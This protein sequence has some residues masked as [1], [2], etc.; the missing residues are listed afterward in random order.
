MVKTRKKKKTPY[1]PPHGYIRIPMPVLA[2][3]RLAAD[4]EGVTQA[5]LL[6]ALVRQ[7]VVERGIE[8]PIAELMAHAEAVEIVRQAW[9]TEL[10]NRWRKEVEEKLRRQ[11]EELHNR[12]FPEQEQEQEQEGETDNVLLES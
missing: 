11:E 7:Y 4:A 10:R 6:E 2:L 9:E 1:R 12:W 3:V 5:G 8:K